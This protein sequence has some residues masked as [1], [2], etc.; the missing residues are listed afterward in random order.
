MRTNSEHQ[1]ELTEP[2]HPHPTLRL[3]RHLADRN[4]PEAER[5]TPSA[6]VAQHG[7]AEHRGK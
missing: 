4:A 2:P 1:N 5:S 6:G 7:Q 3:A